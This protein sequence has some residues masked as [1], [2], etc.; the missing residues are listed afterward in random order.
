MPREPEG[1]AGDWTEGRSRLHKAREASGR[2]PRAAA[3][4]LAAVL[5]CL[6]PA[7]PAGAA[8]AAGGRFI[9]DLTGVSCVSASDCWAV[10]GTG[11]NVPV[12]EHWDGTAWSLVHIPAPR[13][14]Y[15]AGLPAISCT[16]AASCWAV[17]DYG[18]T[19]TSKQLPYAEHWNGTAWSA[20]KLPHPA[21]AFV[22]GLVSVACAS[23]VNCWAVGTAGSPAAPL[24]ERWTGHGWAMTRIAAL[25]ARSDPE[26]V[27]CASAGDCWITGLT[28]RN[29]TL[30]AHWDGRTW[31]VTPTPVSASSGGEL[32]S[33]SCG[34]PA[35]GRNC[36]SVGDNSPH[37][38]AEHWN[39][40]A[41]AVT[42]T[43]SR[44]GFLEGVSC[45]AGFHCLATGNTFSARALS[46]VW[47]GS[48]WRAV[49]LPLPHGA[50]AAALVGVSCVTATDCWSAGSS[51][52]GVNGVSLIEHWNGT[53]WSV[54]S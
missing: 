9:G 42:P 18:A 31:S 45:T 25:G 34:G 32:L 22:S 14:S 5:A 1:R 27:Y 28:G 50:Q 19:A 6:L 40:S 12:T 2:R 41:W 44:R 54:A 15:T 46:E 53:A 13:G 38:L 37:T 30:A 16:G 20:V 26:A 10:G 3:A 35:G 47:N 8:P 11:N 29:D 39:G 51:F 21:G 17:G 33:T 7:A 23:A 43:G 52:N 4:G 36:V 24:I 48:S 49:L